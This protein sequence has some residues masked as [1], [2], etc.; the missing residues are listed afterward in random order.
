M[1]FMCWGRLKLRTW[2][3]SWSAMLWS[4]TVRIVMGGDMN[5]EHALSEHAKA[6]EGRN[7]KKMMSFLEIW[8]SYS[9]TCHPGT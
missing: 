3:P 9:P 6:R 4:Y 7:D 1:D 5:L 2:T 8:H